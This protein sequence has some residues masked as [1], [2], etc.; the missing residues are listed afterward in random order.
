MNAKKLWFG[1]IAVMVISFGVLGYYGREIYRQAP[2]IPDKVV[3]EDGTVLF[4]GQD[5]KDGQNVWQSVGGQEIGT[6]W[7]HGAYQAPDWSA[8]WLHKEAVFI[9][10]KLAMQTE[11]VPYAQVSE[12]KQASLKI[13]LQKDLRTNTYDKAKGTITVSDMRAEAIASN[14]KFYGGLFTND[15]SLAHL[16]DAYSI[17]ENSLKDPERVRLLN[18]FFFWISWAC[19]TERP[20]QDITYTNN[21]PAEKLVANRTNRFNAF[22]DRFQRNYSSGRNRINGSV[23]R[24]TKE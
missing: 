15:P 21:W 3:T 2:P 23:L 20:G 14:T 10:D 8:D 18:T 11:G 9:L 5:I 22:V 1:F 16:R 4:T 13:L 17:P 12:E 7:G 24:K 6:V 19:V